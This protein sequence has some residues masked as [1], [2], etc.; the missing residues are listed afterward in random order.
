MTIVW[1][2]E[3]IDEYSWLIHP[4]SNPKLYFFKVCSAL[5]EEPVILEWTDFYKIYLLKLLL[6]VSSA[7]LEEGESASTMQDPFV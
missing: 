3:R 2:P 7:L 6:P 5:K 1:V 4:P